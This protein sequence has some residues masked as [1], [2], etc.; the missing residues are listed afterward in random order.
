MQPPFPDDP[1][2]LDRLGND[3][4]QAFEAIY[5]RYWK[6]LYDFAYTK[7]HDADAAQEVVQELFVTL[8]ERRCSLQI[9]N[10]QSYLFTSVRNRVIDHFKDKAFDALDSVDPLSEPDYP[11]FLDEL[12]QAMQQAVGQL[13]EKTRKIFVLNRFEGNS[14]RQI[15]AQLHMPERTVEY[16]ITQAL[17]TLKTLLKDFIVLM[18]TFLAAGKF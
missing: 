1:Q 8:W 10:L 9:K 16:H 4:P 7:T 11:L 12:E 13:P 14:V 17:R 5:R 18:L 2:L 6:R 3:D 15:S